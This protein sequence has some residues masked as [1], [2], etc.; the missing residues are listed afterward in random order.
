V[1]CKLAQLHI[2]YPEPEHKQLKL[3]ALAKGVTA[4][5]L[6]RSY[7]QRG[8]DHDLISTT[9]RMRKPANHLPQLEAYTPALNFQEQQV[10]TSI[11]FSPSP[12]YPKPR[13][14][15]ELNEWHKRYFS[16]C[17]LE[18]R[19]RFFD[20]PSGTVYDPSLLMAVVSKPRLV[21]CMLE[22]GKDLKL[23]RV[24]GAIVEVIINRMINQ[25]I[26]ANTRGDLLAAPVLL[27][28]GIAK[29]SIRE[30][31]GSDNQAASHTS[32]MVSE[33]GINQDNTSETIAKQDI[34]ISNDNSNIKEDGN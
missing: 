32:V 16:E 2:E 26:I 19:M 6:A 13:S 31:I 24:H 18:T 5:S 20:N 21:N 10:Q 9:T 28:I 27:L 3:I 12:E 22:R 29:I 14:N 11:Q 7:I 23:F 25:K 15:Y 4:S 17:F 33:L 34:E 1:L 8:I 30:L